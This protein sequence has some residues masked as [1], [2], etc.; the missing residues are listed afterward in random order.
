MN[1]KGEE[2]KEISQFTKKYES[3]E[4]VNEDTQK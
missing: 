1:E 3:E 2:N 4:K